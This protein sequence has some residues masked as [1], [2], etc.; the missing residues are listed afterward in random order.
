MGKNTIRRYRFGNPTDTDAVVLKL[1]AETGEI[2]RLKAEPVIDPETGSEKGIRFSFG[3]DPE[4]I[5]EADRL[6]GYAIEDLE[7]KREEEEQNNG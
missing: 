6:S 4:D 7:H 1:P 3:M 5:R 2:P